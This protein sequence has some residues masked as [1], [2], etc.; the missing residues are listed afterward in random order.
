MALKRMRLG[1]ELPHLTPLGAMEVLWCPTVCTP[2]QCQV[3]RYGTP[4]QLQPLHVK[5]GANLL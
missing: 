2:T 3:P 5:L 4:V 1:F